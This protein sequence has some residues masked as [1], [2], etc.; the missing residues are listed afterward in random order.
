[1]PYKNKLDQRAY[2]RQWAKLNR[3]RKR[4][5]REARQTAEHGEAPDWPDDP[6]GAV[7]AWARERLIVPP[8][9]ANAGQPMALPEYAIDFFRDALAPGVREALCSVARKNSKSAAVAVLILAHIA[10]DGPLRRKGFRAGIASVNREKAGELWLQMSDIARASGLLQ[11]GESARSL[12]FA[13]APR[14]AASDWGMVEFL[15]ADKTAGHASG[16]DLAV[17]DEIGLFPERGRALVAGLLSSTSARDGRLIAISVLGDSPLSREMAERRDDPATIVHVH[18]APANCKLDDPAAWRAANPALGTIKSE[19]YMADMARRAASNPREQAAFRT[20]DLNQPGSPIDDSIVM[21]DRWHECTRE[22]QPIRAGPLYLGID[23]GGS[24][25]MSCAALYWPATGRLESYGAFG[26]QP[27]LATRGEADG[28]GLAYVEMAEDGHMRTFPGRVT[29]VAE[30]LTWIAEML[31][32][33]VPS[34]AL[35]DRYKRA[36][37]EDAIA[38]AGLHWPMEWRAQ[39]A[40]KDGSAD[41]R[42]FQRAVESG[43]LRPGNNLVLYAALANSRLRYDLNGNPALEKAH[44]RGRVDAM[45]ASVLAVGAGERGGEPPP[46]RFVHIP[47]N[48]GVLTA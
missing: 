28:V 6:A 7:Q 42:A 35:A 40:G 10:D 5:E 8:G 32:G 23:V 15:S 16:F 26:D 39:G 4:T 9:H 48:Q 30:F 46:M 31:G 1:M 12:R 24:V 45:A 38:K 34:L 33:Q 20:F 3:A 44:H 29:P 21:L 36:E 25:S 41:I 19:S 37:A 11:D 17:A 43:R 18:A 27:D 13:R 47:F 14:V 22:P 2:Q